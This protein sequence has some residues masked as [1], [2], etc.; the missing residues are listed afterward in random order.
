MQDQTWVEGWQNGG[1]A[2]GAGAPVAPHDGSANAT[3]I[4]N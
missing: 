3:Y 1:G 2:E 4:H